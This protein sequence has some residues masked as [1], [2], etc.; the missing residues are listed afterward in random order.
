MAAVPNTSAGA[1]P[2]PASAPHDFALK[3]DRTKEYA[4]GHCDYFHLA[5]AG[6][7]KSIPEFLRN[8][9]PSGTIDFCPGLHIEIMPTLLPYVNTDGI[10]EDLDL[11]PGSVSNNG[12]VA[13][14]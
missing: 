9:E 10:L 2:A 1:A 13:P 8:Y 4:V 5:P 3:A 7:A 6:H 14:S 12:P 11:R